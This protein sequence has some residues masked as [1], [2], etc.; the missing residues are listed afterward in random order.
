MLSTLLF[1]IKNCFKNRIAELKSKEGSDDD[2]KRRIRRSA[3]N[4][5]RRYKC[6]V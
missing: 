5:E 3:K 1:L 4:I 2:K 6:P